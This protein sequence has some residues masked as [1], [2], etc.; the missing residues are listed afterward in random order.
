[1]MS[2]DCSILHMR[3]IV[4]YNVLA[5][6]S[7]RTH[8]TQAADTITSALSTDSANHAEVMLPLVLPWGA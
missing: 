5:R 1:M 6:Y 4:R 8:T 2:H 7:V 3:M